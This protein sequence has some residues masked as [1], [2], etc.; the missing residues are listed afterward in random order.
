MVN[1][2]KSTQFDLVPIDAAS[3]VAG[4]KDATD[5]V[6]KIDPSIQRPIK[7]LLLPLQHFLHVLLL[8]ADFGEDVAHGAGEDGD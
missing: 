2:I 4:L 8:R 1:A 5:V 3:Q 6:V 7:R